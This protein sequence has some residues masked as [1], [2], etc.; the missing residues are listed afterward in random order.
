MGTHKC[1]HIKTVLFLKLREKPKHRKN[2]PTFHGKEQFI[3]KHGRR[4]AFYT[5]HL[6]S[7]YKDKEMIG[8]IGFNKIPNLGM[9]T[10]G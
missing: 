4:Y 3:V 5:V 7:A 8:N 6:W 10:C 2:F 1:G 9:C